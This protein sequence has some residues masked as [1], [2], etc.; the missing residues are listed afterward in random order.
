MNLKMMP[1]K[2]ERMEKLA[3]CLMMIGLIL[4]PFH[5]RAGLY[6]ELIASYARI[7]MIFFAGMC[8][9]MYVKEKT[10]GFTK[11]DKVMLAIW[12]V[13]TLLLVFSDQGKRTYSTVIFFFNDLL[14][15]VIVLYRFEENRFEKFMKLF[16][17]IFNS[18]IVV[19]LLLGFVEKFTGKPMEIMTSLVNSVEYTKYFNR[20]LNGPQS[21]EGWRYFSIWGHALTNAVYFTAFFIINDLYHYSRNKRYPKLIFFGI[22]VVGIALCSARAAMAIVVVYMIISSVKKDK[23]IML[24]GVV[25]VAAGYFSGVFD[26]IIYRLKNTSLDSGRFLALKNYF[27]DGRYPLRFLQGYSTSTVQHTAMRVYYAGFEYPMMMAALDHGILFSI[28]M[29]VGIYV[30]GTIVILKQ[31]NI[32]CWIGFSL[33]FAVLNSYNGVTIINQD[34]YIWMSVYL[35]VVF[36]CAKMKKS[37]AVEA[38]EGE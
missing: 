31:K 19:L 8:I 30:Y 21:S 26:N 29:W 23:R 33:L 5:F 34:C 12:F 20:M 10:V 18:F 35:M 24:A 32:M 3:I 14:P 27:A 17:S 37:T 15:I 4:M 28:L 38:K 1:S 2:A 36:N 13:C 25:L 7:N 6:K 9:L 22:S 11:W 16:L